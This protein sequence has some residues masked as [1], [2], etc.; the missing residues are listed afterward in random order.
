[1]TKTRSTKSALIASILALCLCFTMLLGTTFAWFTDSVTS[2][3]NVIMA[4]NLDIVVEYTL[5]GE[6]WN[7]LDGADDLFQKGAW[8]PGHTEVV[9]LRIKN[10]GNLAL[11]YAANMNIV[12]EKIGTNKDG[13]DIVLSDILTVS[14]LTFADTGIDPVFGINIGQR[15]IE[16]A[17]KNEN[18]IAYGTAVSFKEGSVLEKD[19]MLVPGAIDYVV[20]KVDMAETVGD[21][22]NAKDKDSVPS[23]EF[24]I[25][26]LATQLAYESD[27]F[28]NQ[29]D[30]G[31]QYPS[32]VDAWDGTVDT[33][34]YN[35][36]DTEFTLTSAEQLAGLAELANE[37]NTFSKKTIEL[38]S[39]MD[40][41][42]EQWTTIKKFAGTLNGNDHTISNFSVDATAA[43][44]GFID[45]LEWGTIKDLTLTDVNATVGDYRFGVLARS[46]NQSNIDNVTVKDVNVTT[47]APSAF[48]AGLFAHGTVNSNMEVNNCTV[49]NLTVNAEAGAC[50]IGGI[51]TFVQKNGTE[52]EGTNVFENLNVKN[53]K[54]TVNDTDG[55]C[56]VGGLVGQTQTV[57]QNPRFNNCTVTGLDITAT[58]KV[59]VGGFICYPGS[60]TFAENCTA[61]G[62][63]DVSGVTSADNFAGGFFGNYGWG[64]NVGKGDHKVISCSADVDI[65]TKVA[66]AGGFV[67]S[68]TNSEGRNKNITL[69][70]CEAKG[71]VTLVEGGTANIGGFAGQTDRGIYI[72][73]S[74]AQ[75]PFIGKVLDG[76]NL[77]DD[78]NGTLTVSK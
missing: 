69:T 32:S 4:G 31:A 57:W 3:S 42:G 61:E 53:F 44:G 74:A 39:S 20:V 33:S 65:I 76:Y 6:N 36:T 7:D 8:E 52:A 77:V 26:V 71:T 18:G 30:A 78:G 62:K 24:G 70:N 19:K 64:D 16:E 11:K 14:T 50:L 72:N 37:G 25:N 17:F 51:T 67:G 1:M 59:D 23:I 27:S 46:I 29:Y 47:T 28:G 40:L 9:A 45:V 10:N 5:D 41:N 60:V 34:W 55:V 48:V 12:N 13:A 35:E 58:G 63:I 22:A 56:G 54:V 2:S 73:C 66:S 38:E 49:E 68:G 15:S 43:H 21:E 75:A